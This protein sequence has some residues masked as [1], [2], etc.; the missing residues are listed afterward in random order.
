MQ[1]VR[2]GRESKNLIIKNVDGYQV[3]KGRKKIGCSFLFSQKVETVQSSGSVDAAAYP[4]T[5]P[6]CLS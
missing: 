1:E 5:Y 4:L 6:T 3:E 2:Y